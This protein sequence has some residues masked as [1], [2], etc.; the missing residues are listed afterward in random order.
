M[1]RIRRNVAL[2]A[3]IAAAV[4]LSP[5]GS[6]ATATT[7]TVQTQS[8]RS[9]VI[10]DWERTAIRTIYTEGLSPVPVGVLYLGFTSL[11]MDDAVQRAH[12]R[13]HTSGVAAAAVAAHDVLLAYFP[14]SQAN[15]DADLATSLA[16]VHDGKAKTRGIAVGGRAAARMIASRV[17]DG[18]GDLTIVYSRAPAPGVWQ[19]PA[20]GAMLAP[21][22]GYVDPL[23][24]KHRVATDGPDSLTSAAYAA[25]YDEVLR[26]GSATS[27]ERSA[28]QTETALFFTANPPA[29]Y[30]DALVR[31]LEANPLSLAR[32]A[33]LF[34]AMHAA[35]ADTIINAWRLK[36]EVGFWR[37]FQAIAGADTDGNDATTAVPGWTPLVPNPPYS[38]YVTGHGSVTSA[39]IEVIRQLLG[40]HTALVLRSSVTGTER[41]YSHLSTIEHQALGARIWGGLHFRDAMEDGYRMGH[42]TAWRVLNTLC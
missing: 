1:L 34:A 13:G 30:A 6:T 11:A 41:S 39:T 21:W 9:Q 19:P 28:W 33:K 35:V 42:K 27:T 25:D 8:S 24:V 12:R 3:I 26:L 38:D 10:L 32:T 29:M 23:V 37:P 40:E 14:A 4:P 2:A 15:L 17:D 5:I 16:T 36:Y 20:G 18:R 22:L 31:H 7:V